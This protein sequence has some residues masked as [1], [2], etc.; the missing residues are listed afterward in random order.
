ML[1]E[2]LEQDHRQEIRPDEAAR[3]HMEGRRRLRD[4]LAFAA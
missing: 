1:T 2:L 4:R 3:R